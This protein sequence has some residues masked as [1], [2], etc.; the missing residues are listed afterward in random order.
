MWD[1]FFI[2]KMWKSANYSV[3]GAGKTTIVYGAF[4]YLNSKQ[5]NE[6]D[7][8]IVIGPKNSFKSWKDEFV[9]CFA[10]KKQLSLFNIQD[11]SFRNASDRNMSLMLDTANK[12]VILINYD[13][14]DSIKDILK[15]LINDRT[16]L[17][18]DEVHKVKAV[19][20]VWAS[21]AMYISPNAKYKV[22]LT[23]TPIPNSYVDL[24]SQLNILFSDEYKSFFKFTPSEMARKDD[25]TAK[26]INDAIQPFFCRTTKKDLLVPPPNDDDLLISKMTIDEQKL[27]SLIRKKY[28][29]NGLAMYVRLLQASNN[30]KLLLNDLNDYDIDNLFDS[31]EDENLS[32]A[33]FVKEKLNKEGFTN[34]SDRSFINGFDMT[35]KFWNG[36]S[37]VDELVKEGKQV[38]VWGI[39]VNTIERIEEELTKRGIKCKIIYGATP[40]EDRETIIEQFKDKTIN[41]L[42]TNPHTLAESV[43]LHKTCHDSVYFEYSFNL[44]HMLQSR[45][46]INRLGLKEN[47][48]TQYYYLMLQSIIPE[49]DSIDFRTYERLKEKEQIMLNA[50]EGEMLQQINFEVMDDVKRI[51]NMN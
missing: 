17:V 34:T 2:T 11:G 15:Q 23:G 21:A 24:Y 33:D 44:T 5:V 4:A 36:I 22:I 29:R 48:Y 13:L 47:D 46:R 9:E 19:S 49:D 25:N 12:N 37:K 45:D 43:S 50:I 7:K 38:L 39:F 31:E 27:F 41:V 14:L 3:P 16:M 40:L 6:V 18:F 32:E 28:N 8:L 42:I 20:G 1:A 10:D 26:R 51:L 30:P 35:S